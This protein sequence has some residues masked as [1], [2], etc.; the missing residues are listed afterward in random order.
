[1]WSASVPLL[2]HIVVPLFILSAIFRGESKGKSRVRV[3]T[4]GGKVD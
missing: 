4:L 1:M 3:F 2:V